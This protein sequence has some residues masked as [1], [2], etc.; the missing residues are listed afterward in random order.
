LSC[1]CITFRKCG[2]NVGHEGPNERSPEGL[3]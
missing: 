3:Q 2:M 1:F